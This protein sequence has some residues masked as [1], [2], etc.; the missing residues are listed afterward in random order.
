M[1]GNEHKFDECTT[2]FFLLEPTSLVDDTQAMSMSSQDIFSDGNNE[3]NSGSP[4]STNAFIHQSSIS[5]L[6]KDSIGEDS[7]IHNDTHNPSVEK[8]NTMQ[9]SAQEEQSLVESAKPLSGNLKSIRELT[10]EN[11]IESPSDIFS[12]EDGIDIW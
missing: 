12:P 7:G 2:V 3:V 6:P 11:T 1:S 10:K 9:S 5:S 4:L 8:A